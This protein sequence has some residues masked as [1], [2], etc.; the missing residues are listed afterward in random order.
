M[1]NDVLILTIYFLVVIYVLYQMA[2]TIES[3]LDDKVKVELDRKN[4]EAEV[5]RQ[6]ERQSQLEKLMAKVEQL[7]YKGIKLPPYLALK[8]TSPSNPQMQLPIRITVTPM[9][10]MSRNTTHKSL[11]IEV[12]NMTDDAQVYI[13]WDKSSVSTIGSTQRV[14]RTGIPIGSDLSRGQIF[15]VVNPG[16]LFK[17]DIT[18]ENC[19]SINPETS[20]LEAKKTLIDM[21][22]V[23]MR[24]SD[25]LDKID[26]FEDEEEFRL[27]AYSLRLMIGIR[28]I[29]NQQKNHTTYLLLPFNFESVLLPDEIAFPPLRWLLN[30]PRPENARDALTTLLLGRSPRR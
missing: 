5:N 11:K 20:T 18:G 19:L 27:I 2:L 24:L 13:D 17:T 16:D 8:V 28:H 1:S 30:R 29:T 25:P 14:V 10:K 7:T 23:I 15:S 26:S 21:S 12:H 22:R 3:N 9:G 6:L 4:L